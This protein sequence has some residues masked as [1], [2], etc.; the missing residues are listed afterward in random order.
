MIKKVSMLWSVLCN[1]TED[2]LIFDLTLSNTG[3][4]KLCGQ[5]KSYKQIHFSARQPS[6]W[7]SQTRSPLIGQSVTD[8]ASDWPL[9]TADI[10]YPLVSVTGSAGCK[11]CKFPAVDNYV[12][13]RWQHQ[14]ADINYFIYLNQHPEAA[15]SVINSG[16]VMMGGLDLQSTWSSPNST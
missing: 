6:S 12:G 15:L 5:L 10:N 3:C 13:W 4:I 9:I 8:L 16:L 1:V 2:G 14:M 7:T 11:Y